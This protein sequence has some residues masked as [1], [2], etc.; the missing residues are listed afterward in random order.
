MTKQKVMALAIERIRPAGRLALI[1]H[2]RNSKSGRKGFFRFR[3]NASKSF[4]VLREPTEILTTSEATQSPSCLLTQVSPP[5]G[6][7][8]H[9]LTR[10]KMK[11]SLCWTGG[12]S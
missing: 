7:R 2:A 10:M 9:I 12:M 3:L 11:H 6:G 5:G 8:L 4:A 1:G